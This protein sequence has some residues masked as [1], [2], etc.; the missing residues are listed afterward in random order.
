[1][2]DK[3][4]FAKDDKGNVIPQVPSTS[5][6]YT[7][8]IAANT[9]GN[10]LIPLGYN[11]CVLE[12]TGAGGILSGWA[13]INAPSATPT[14]MPCHGYNP[15]KHGITIDYRYTQ[16]KNIYYRSLA[17]AVTLTLAFYKI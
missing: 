16:G 6:A 1:M 5:E 2:V 14:I 10:V 7:F 11:Y 3:L 12:V 17:E 13:T 9:S 4:Y 15:G 8:S